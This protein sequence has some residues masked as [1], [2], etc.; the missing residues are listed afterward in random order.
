M[1]VAALLAAAPALAGWEQQSS[2][3]GVTVDW[4]RVDGAR[5]RQIRAT[6]TVEQPLS[7]LLAVLKDIEHY[8]DFMPPTEA[9]EV[10]KVDA[11]TK[12]VHVTINPPWVSRRDYCVAV[13]W[14]QFADGTVGSA[15]S[16]FDDGC[17]APQKGVVRHARTEGT[18]RLRAVDDKHTYV[19]YTAITD[20]GGSLPAWMIDR[21]TVKA[22]RSMFAT[23]AT[24]ASDAVYGAPVTPASAAALK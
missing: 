12:W 4:R 14:T 9:V 1:L 20:P 2:D 7:R 18:W 11:T 23:L 5:V 22:M 17:P 21:A 16:Q 13:R 15:W 24:R 3:H 8:P 19:E 10:L 6:G